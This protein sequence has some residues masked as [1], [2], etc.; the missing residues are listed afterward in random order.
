MQKEIWK[1]IDGFEDSY[2][3]SDTGNVW[4]NK[5]NQLL[6]PMNDGNGYYRVGLYKNGKCKTFRIARLVANA[7]LINLDNKPFVDHIDRNRLNNCIKNLRWSTKSENAINSNPQTKN[8]KSN[9]KG[10]TV[11]SNNKYRSRI[12]INTNVISLGDFDTQEEA[13][14]AYNKAALNY[15]GEFAH[16][17]IID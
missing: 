14:K 8:K 4:S 15:F 7:F 16:L 5:N 13:A 9:Y 2:L 1:E 6:N 12:T 11:R 10:V 17:N 3:I